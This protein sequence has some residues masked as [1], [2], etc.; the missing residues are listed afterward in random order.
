MANFTPFTRAQAVPL[1]VRCLVWFCPC[2]VGPTHSLVLSLDS[3]MD[4]AVCFDCFF[5]LPG[6]STGQGSPVIM[7]A[8][9]L[10]ATMSCPALY[11]YLNTLNPL[12]PFQ[13]QD[14]VFLVWV[15]VQAVQ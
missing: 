11:N 6:N 9:L 5:S 7:T 10:S 1:V 4:A 2:L 8:S 15:N 14:L 13:D 3:V 12:V